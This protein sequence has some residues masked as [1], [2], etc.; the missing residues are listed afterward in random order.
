MWQTFQMSS[1]DDL[2]PLGMARSSYE[3]GALDAA[4]LSADPVVQVAAWIAEA[5]A[6]GAEEPSAM[7]LATVDANGRPSTRFVLARKVESGRIVFFTNYE[8]RK[9]KEL[10]ANPHVAATFW[11]PSLERQIRIEGLAQR[12]SSEDS[13][14]YFASRPRDS[15][16]ASAVSPQSREIKSLD[17]LRHEMARLDAQFPTVLPRPSH[18]GGFDILPSRIEFWQGRRAR[19]HDRILF[20]REDSG[21]LIR[22][23]AP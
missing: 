12:S 23:L 5:A 11:W 18:W 16:L 22:R 2:L 3:R 19:L 10:E 14:T 20:E 13:N 17:D 9:A 4:D 7:A 1:P 15:Q 8:S 6:A 21:W